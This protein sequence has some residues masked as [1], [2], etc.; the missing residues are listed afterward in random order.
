MRCGRCCQ[1]KGNGA[2]GVGIDRVRQRALSGAGCF[3]VAARPVHVPTFAV[4]RL[5]ESGTVECGKSL[6]SA[7]S[8]MSSTVV[9][10]A[11]TAGR[12]SF[13]ATPCALLL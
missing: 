13:Q 1:S 7:L 11:K 4:G 5:H 8:S 9:M 10:S 2:D 3:R 6:T 12:T